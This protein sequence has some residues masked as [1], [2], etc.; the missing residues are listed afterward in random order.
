VLL[1]SGGGWLGYWLDRMDALAKSP[2]RVTLPLRELPST[3]VRRQCWISAD[4][5]ER[6]LP[7]M[8]DYVGADRFL[9]ATDYP[10]S[11]HGADYMTELRQLAAALPAA[12]R[13][14]LLGE[15]A[16]RLYRL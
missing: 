11:D 15:N 3:Y 2:L 4:P 7:S 10:H 9:W 8:I 6:T 12:A 16:I 13:G 5:D 14:G 1:E